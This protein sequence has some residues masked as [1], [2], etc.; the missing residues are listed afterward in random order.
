MTRSRCA[1]VHDCML[2]R[3]EPDGSGAD[4]E[5]IAAHLHLADPAADPQSVRS[6]RAAA[7]RD[8]PGGAPAAVAYLTR[9][10]DEPPPESERGSLLCELADAEMLIRSPAAIE[11]LRAALDGDS[12]DPV[13]RAR[14][15]WRL[16]DALLFAGE[17]DE[18]KALLAE[19]V[20]DVRGREDD[21][22][23]RLEGRL[24]T[25]GTL[26]GRAAGKLTD[27]NL[28]RLQVRAR[29][30]LD[31]AR[32]LRLNL[33]LLLAVRARR[34]E[35]LP[36]LI[37]RGLD[38]GRFL[39]LET[40][41]AIEAVHAAFALVLIDRLQDALAL[42]EQMLA[43]AAA[44]GSVLGFLAGSTFRSL[45]HLR[46]GALVDAEG[47]AFATLELAREL[48]LHFTIPFIAG[49]LALT[50]N[51]RGR[52][53][54]AAELL[55]SVSLPAPLAGTPA[56]VTLLE[57]RGRVHRA[58]GERKTAIEDLRACGEACEGLEVSNPNVVAW[59]SELA[60]ALG[61]DAAE[62][63]RGLVE[64]E[65]DLARRAGIPRGVGVAL[66]ASAALAQTSEREALLSEAIATL[67]GSPAR[68]ELAHALVDL[69]AHYRREGHRTKA[70]E[71][72]LRGLELRTSVGPI[73]SSS[74]PVR[75][76]S[77]LA[78]VLAGRG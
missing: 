54:E 5:A 37:E 11:H 77:P 65:L 44:R 16:S 74:V 67:E 39:A 10:L 35:E 61:Q 57:A 12:G 18:A 3:H 56:G 8:P 71:E 58:R 49:Y 32:P 64:R 43:D 14:L 27:E 19:A 51:E 1:G 52:T 62:E 41:D 69:G 48:Q 42:T 50:L 60:L 78:L 20:E 33:A 29:E 15:R 31:G 7:V 23:L 45:V 53:D 17:W 34:G 4:P 70:R 25:L 28:A 38:G 68:L 22:M 21:L 76:C 6:L 40:A 46:R 75:S 72:L 47:D 73:H 30:D 59:R 36:P 13:Q 9:A 26:D 63:A 55:E 66:R 2:S 24:V